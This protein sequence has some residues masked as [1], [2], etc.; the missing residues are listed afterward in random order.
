MRESD[1]LAKPAWQY[2][3]KYHLKWIDATTAD[4]KDEL[5]RYGYKTRSTPRD[6][7]SVYSA[8]RPESQNRKV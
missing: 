2:F 3:S 7:D 1:V 5:I 8:E 4:R 6:A